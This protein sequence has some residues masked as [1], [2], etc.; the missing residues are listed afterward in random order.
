MYSINVLVKEKIEYEASSKI[1]FISLRNILA[2]V[3]PLYPNFDAWLNFTFRRNLNSDERQ[4]VL[5][6]NGNQ[7]AGVAL[8]KNTLDEKKIS[9]LYTCPQFRGQNIGHNLIELALVEL[10]SADTFI[11]VSKER[12]AEL[13]PLLK[14]KGFKLSQSIDNLYREDNTEHF[15]KL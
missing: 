11:T 3:S 15:Y 1:D 8:L 10:D 13:Y 4:L 5:A 14:S 7:I 9:T 6:Y 12:N 2:D